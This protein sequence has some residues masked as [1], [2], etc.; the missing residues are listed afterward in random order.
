MQAYLGV[1]VGSVSTNLVVIN[2]DGKVLV[3]IYLRTAGQPIQVV[4]EG[5]R[6]VAEAVRTNRDLWCGR[7]GCRPDFDG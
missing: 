7:D 6:Q 2:E 3:D 1:D 5:M 4:Q